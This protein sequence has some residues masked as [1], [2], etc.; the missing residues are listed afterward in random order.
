MGRV[1]AT[2]SS[3]PKS[4]SVWRRSTADSGS[5]LCECHLLCLRTGCQ[6]G[7]LDQT[8][9]CPH[10]TAHD[11]FLAWVEAGVFEKLWQAGV[12]QFDELQGIDWEW[13]SMDGAMVKAP[14]GGKKKRPQPNR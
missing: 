8:E 9:I 10:S 12:N 4:T 6:W 13:L 7:A 1:A 14:L 3:S 11:R 2:N 5:D